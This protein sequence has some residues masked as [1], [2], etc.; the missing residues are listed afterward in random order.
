MPM[1]LVVEVPCVIWVVWKLFQKCALEPL[2]EDFD[3][4][5]REKRERV[6]I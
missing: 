2:S 5:T 4:E 3:R 1:L 6:K